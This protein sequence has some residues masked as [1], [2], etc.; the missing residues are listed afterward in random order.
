MHYRL[1]YVTPLYVVSA[2]PVN[3]Q[4]CCGK[5]NLIKLMTLLCL[6]LPPGAYFWLLFLPAWVLFLVLQVNLE[7]PS[8]TNFPPPLPPLGALWDAQ[9][10]G[11]VILWI[12]FQALLYILPVG[13][14]NCT[15]KDACMH[16]L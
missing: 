12:L 4:T 7:D 5:L 8:L 10:L 14:V 15:H 6:P 1:N 13:K 11:F 9:A 16:E 2:K 3:M